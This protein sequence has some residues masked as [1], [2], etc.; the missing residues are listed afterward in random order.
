MLYGLYTAGNKSILLS[1]HTCDKET[2]DKPWG[3]RV[4]MAVNEKVFRIKNLADRFFYYYYH[5]K[6]T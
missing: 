4:E 3:N 1:Y 6:L 5:Y 2:T